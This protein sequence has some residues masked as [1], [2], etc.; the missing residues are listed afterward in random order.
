MSSLRCGGQTKVTL[1]NLIS[2]CSPLSL[3][4]SSE[5]GQD[6]G[7]TSNQESEAKVSG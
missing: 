3:I 4:P 6:L 7:L 1:S 2:H 5:C